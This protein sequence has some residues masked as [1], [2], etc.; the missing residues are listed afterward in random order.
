MAAAT[1]TDAGSSYTSTPLCAGVRAYRAQPSDACLSH[2]SPRRPTALASDPRLGTFVGLLAE[3]FAELFAAGIARPHQLAPW[4]VAVGG[5]RL[6]RRRADG[7]PIPRRR[8]DQF[9][10]VAGSLRPDHRGARSRPR[11]GRRRRRYC[12]RRCKLR[13]LGDFLG[14]VLGD[15]PVRG[16]AR[17]ERWKSLSRLSHFQSCGRE[18][19]PIPRRFCRPAARAPPRLRNVHR[20]A[21]PRQP[22]MCARA[23][24]AP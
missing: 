10:D 4:R 5:R 22:P 8:G 24:I 21:P 12:R 18:V 3:I 14:E 17:G 7:D 11:T 2:R 6:L 13:Q 16:H 9:S 15:I 20:G 1:T 23:A 19:R